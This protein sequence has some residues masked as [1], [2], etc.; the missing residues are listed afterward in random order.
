MQ[1]LKIE[2]P[3]LNRDNELLYIE[4]LKAY[5][6]NDFEKAYRITNDI[7]NLKI[8]KKSGY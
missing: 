2:R 4:A 3:R 5:S 1:K 6:E 7:L 8:L